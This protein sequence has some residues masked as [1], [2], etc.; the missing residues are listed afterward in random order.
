[1]AVVKAKKAIAKEV[2]S[3]KQATTTELSFANKFPKR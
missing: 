2:H 1:M 3:A